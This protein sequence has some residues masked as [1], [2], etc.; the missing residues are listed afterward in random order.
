MQY[1]ISSVGNACSKS[2]NDVKSPIFLFLA[3]FIIAKFIL[4]YT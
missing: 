4:C 3:F 2:N 1:G